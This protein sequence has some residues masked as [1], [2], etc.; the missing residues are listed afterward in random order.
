MKSLD[1]LPTDTIASDEKWL[2]HQSG[3][4]RNKAFSDRQKKRSRTRTYNH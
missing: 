1:D 4:R 2:K 3:R